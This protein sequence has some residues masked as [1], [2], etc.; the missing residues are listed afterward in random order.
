[1][2]MDPQCAFSVRAMQQLTPFIAAGKIRLNVIPLSILDNE[3][4]GLST[5]SALNLVSAPSDQLVTDWATGHTTGTPAPD[6]AGKL[7][8]NMAAAAAIGLKG[9]PTFLWHKSDGTEGRLDGVPPDM[10]ALL[11]SIGG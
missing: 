7:Q 1:M 3:D 8:A 6:A 11:A 9:T 4:N 10:N 2:F 5:R